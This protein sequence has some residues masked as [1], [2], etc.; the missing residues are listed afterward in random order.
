VA[1]PISVMFKFSGGVVDSAVP[2]AKSS[3]GE[4]G[5]DLICKR[6]VGRDFMGGVL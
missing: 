6:V 3:G 1:T 4:V 5:T 2:T